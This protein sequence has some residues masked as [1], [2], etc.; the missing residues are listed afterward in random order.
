MKYTI[1][2]TIA[3]VAACAALY[4]IKPA[5]GGESTEYVTEAHTGVTMDEFCRYQTLMVQLG[6]RW[7]HNGCP[8]YLKPERKPE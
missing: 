3:I 5:S 8:F 7:V 4:A 6:G 2:T 1:R